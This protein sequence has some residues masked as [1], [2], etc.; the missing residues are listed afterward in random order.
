MSENKPTTLP[1]L[2]QWHEPTTRTLATYT[3]GD[4]L[5]SLPVHTAATRINQG[6]E[7]LHDQIT[8]LIERLRP[9][10]GPDL[11][12]KAGDEPVDVNLDKSPHAAALG[13]L[14]GRIHTAIN[15]LQNTVNRLEI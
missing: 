5:D 8:H 11:P 6:I 4:E 14:A 10:L 9:V 2:G 12:T 15:R 3:P 13:D 1:E 7:S